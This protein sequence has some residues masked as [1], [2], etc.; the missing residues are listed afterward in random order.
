MAVRID[1]YATLNRM[2][3]VPVERIF[4]V[5]V[6]LVSSQSHHVSRG[7]LLII[8]TIAIDIS[9]ILREQMR[10]FLF[11]LLLI[12]RKNFTSVRVVIAVEV[13]RR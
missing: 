1:T 2:L 10:T 7:H 13:A 8:I 12:L 4:R 3:F 6:L 5:R 9:L 11:E